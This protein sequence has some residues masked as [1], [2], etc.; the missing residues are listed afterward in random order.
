MV[1]GRGRTNDGKTFLVLGLS[2]GNLE[3]LRDGRPMHLTHKP[4]PFIPEDLMIL[5]FSGQTE[6]A[7]A[8]QLHDAGIDL[9][10]P[11]SK[12]NA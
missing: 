12:G 10:G 5:I 8:A 9:H 11:E 4:H 6:E 1:G 2:E 7:M 3:R